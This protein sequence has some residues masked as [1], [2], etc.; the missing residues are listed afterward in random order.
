MLV[1]SDAV[2]AE[3][4]SLFED[5]VRRVKDVL[6][7]LPGVEPGDIDVISQFRAGP[8]SRFGLALVRDAP[9]H[10]RFTESDPDTDVI[11]TEESVAAV[12]PGANLYVVIYG[13]PTYAGC[14]RNRMMF[15]GLDTASSTIRHEVGHSLAG[16]HDERSESTN[17]STLTADDANCTA[18]PDD[19]PWK[20]VYTAS[21][22][23]G[24]DTSLFLYR[25]SNRCI[26]ISP[27]V[28]E[29]FCRVC[30]SLFETLFA[31]S[32]QASNSR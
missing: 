29:Q 12:D 7:S 9:C 2:R 21:P 19:P 17:R 20:A 5:Q 18:N 26:M 22:Q 23:A 6:A 28:S 31:Q 3:H 13:R 11:G 10:F 15:I 27:G 8:L 4:K 25:P 1:L 16:L 30:A 14:A 32:R 24:C